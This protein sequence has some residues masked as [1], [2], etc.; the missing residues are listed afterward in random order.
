MK[1]IIS[2]LLLTVC[3][4][5]NTMTANAA[6]N[7]DWRAYPAFD[8][9][10]DLVI[11]T[12][13]R[14]YFIGKSHSIVADLPVMASEDYSLFFLD[15]ESDEISDA[16]TRYNMASPTVRYINYNPYRKYLF[17]AYDDNNID[18]LFDS[19][20]TANISALKN[21]SIPGSKNIRFA[22]FDR[23]RN[24]LWVA[25]D[26]GYV[27]IDDKTFTVKESRNYSVPLNCVASVGDRLFV[28]FDGNLY[29]APLDE[30]RLNFYDY[31]MHDSTEAAKEIYPI[32]TNLFVLRGNVSN[33]DNKLLSYRVNQD[34]SITSTDEVQGYY[35]TSVWPVADGGYRAMCNSNSYVFTSNNGQSVRRSGI[36]RPPEDKGIKA[37]SSWDSREYFTLI[38]RK[39]LRSYKSAKLGSTEFALTRGESMPNATPVHFSRAIASHPRYGALVSNIGVDPCFN[40]NMLQEPI[41][42]SGLK[43]GEWTR[44]GFV[45]TNPEQ[46]NVGLNPVGLLIDPQDDKYVYFGSRGSGMT[47]LNLEDP[48]DVLHYSFPN[49]PTAGLPGYFE[50]NPV[51]EAWRNICHNSA[52]KV[53]ATGNL[54]TF[55]YLHKEP[56]LEMQYLTPADRKASTNASTARPFRKL[57][58]STKGTYLS[59]NSQ[60][61][62]LTHSSNK[63][64]IL[65]VDNTTILIVDHK[66]T[67]DNTSDDQVVVLQEF[68]DQDGG[69]ASLYLPGFMYEDQSTGIVWIGSSAGIYYV[70]PR[71]LL[72]GQ[73]IL[74]RVKV[75]R[76]DGTSLADYL[77]SG[78][79]VNGMTEDASGRK[80]LG[81]IG[82][83]VVV[84]S[85][86][87]KTII[88]EFTAANSGL[89][90]DNIYTIQYIPETNSV[91]IATDRGV[92]EFFIGGSAERPALENEVRAYPNPV[93]PDYYGWVTIDGLP[94][95]AL[96]KIVDAQGS[97]V[98]E[99]GRAESGVAQWDVYNM[100]HQRVK[101]G[102]YYVLS[103]SSTGGNESNVAKILVMN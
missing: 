4:L 102:V 83:G 67:L 32:D 85:A 39:G 28:T 84:T 87:C 11:D 78:V 60:V 101:T 46:K 80:W 9:S 57:R 69:R 41:N 14:V 5:L 16:Y 89:L 42:L 47:R 74:N 91:M 1:H 103:S 92:C 50:A 75:A 17:V 72:Q 10:A 73:A 77:L 61:L 20:E 49:D 90:S 44:Y 100:H 3:A 7:G 53:D 56:V 31:T 79:G 71:N 51:H 48:Q 30:P 40:T 12:P 37:S 6:I 8:N 99:L 62:P 81:T 66:G 76:N 45:Y 36:P 68:T 94:D 82:A 97:L 2:A 13:D 95:N 65:Y 93:A 29:S 19:G 27:A 54:W 23:T 58:A 21:A 22:S 35:V 86:D 25:T 55:H 24:L 64:Y 18:L 96:V 43:N 38:P 34:G 88:A 98:R 59:Y 15:K 52:P 33:S 26:F 70:Q 63:N